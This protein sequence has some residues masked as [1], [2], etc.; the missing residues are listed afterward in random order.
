[1]EEVIAQ[2][3]RHKLGEMR[4]AFHRMS[5]CKSGVDEDDERGNFGLR[6]SKMNEFHVRKCDIYKQLRNEETTYHSKNSTRDYQRIDLI[7]KPQ[8]RTLQYS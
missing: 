5:L 4:P 2:T 6:V 3:E 8:N 7:G 1:M